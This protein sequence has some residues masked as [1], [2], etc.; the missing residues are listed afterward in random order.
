[1]THLRTHLRVLRSPRRRQITQFPLLPAGRHPFNFTGGGSF[2]SFVQSIFPIWVLRM[3]E[4]GEIR[5]SGVSFVGRHL[6]SFFPLSPSF[7]LFARLSD[8]PAS[9]ERK[10]RFLFL[11]LFLLFFVFF[12]FRRNRRQGSHFSSSSSF[13]SLSRSPGALN[14]KT[15]CQKLAPTP[16]NHYL[17]PSPSPSLSYTQVGVTGC[18]PPKRRCL[19]GRTNALIRQCFRYCVQFVAHM[20]YNKPLYVIKRKQSI[21]CFFHV[22]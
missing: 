5:L 15:H 10:R 3:K 8:A 14:C 1:M 11:L 7:Q 9:P 12:F 6:S 17:P 2:S 13:P 20:R 19:L 4:W 18:S 22:W 21:D 16:Y